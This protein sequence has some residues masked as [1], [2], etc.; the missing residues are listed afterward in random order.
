MNW[1]DYTPEQRVAICGVPYPKVTVCRRPSYEIQYEQVGEHTF[2][3]VI[4][5]KWTAGAKVAFEQNCNALQL[6]LD[7][8]V[9]V[10]C[11]LS[12]KKLFKFCTQFG[13]E[14]A[15]DM[16]TA[17]GEPAVVLIRNKKQWVKA[18]SAAAR[19]R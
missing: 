15:L 14:P 8:P 9:H 2:V 4:V 7:G 18:S 11:P 19:Q 3:H 12:D 10:L 16:V 5:H 1:D 17:E 13:F 6:L